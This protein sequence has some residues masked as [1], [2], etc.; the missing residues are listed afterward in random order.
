MYDFAGAAADF[1]HL[2]GISDAAP[3]AKLDEV[4]SWQDRSRRARDLRDATHYAVLGLQQRADDA[5]IR[6]AYRKASMRWCVSAHQSS[7]VF[8]EERAR[9]EGHFRRIN[10]AKE[11][12]LDSYKRAV[13]D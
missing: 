8:A 2:A 9:A 1:D 13:Y 10:E 4:R 7:S 11:T 12:L 6:R 3:G 5:E